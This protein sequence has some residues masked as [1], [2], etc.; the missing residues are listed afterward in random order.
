MYRRIMVGTDGS[1]YSDKAVDHALELCRATGAEL[2]AVS[3]VDT[4]SLES[5]KEIDK[6]V[7]D[8]PEEDLELL[9]IKILDKVEEKASRENVPLK[10]IIQK[11]DPA[12]VLVELAKRENADLLVVGTRGLL[13]VKRV[14]LGSST[15]KI[16]RWSGVPVLV[17][18]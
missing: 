6:K 14:M 8:K 15:Q 4:R 3:V 11:G 12:S 17:V 2:I 10:R 9:A 1:E 16:V 18:R 13:G 5:I 7:Y